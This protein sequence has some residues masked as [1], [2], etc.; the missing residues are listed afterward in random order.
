MYVYIHIPTPTYILIYRKLGY[1]A[2]SMLKTNLL[3]EEACKF[4]V[5]CELF[6]TELH[7]FAIFTHKATLPFLSCIKMCTQEEL[8][9]NFLKLRH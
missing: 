4:Y 1:S 9:K 7:F 5:N 6:I 8:L 3:I 2:A